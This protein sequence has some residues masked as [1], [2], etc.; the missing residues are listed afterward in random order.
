MAWQVL[1]N[2]G[3]A[4]ENWK[5]RF[6]STLGGIHKLYCKTRWWIKR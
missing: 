4:E 2:M 5:E 3:S 1:D 6:S